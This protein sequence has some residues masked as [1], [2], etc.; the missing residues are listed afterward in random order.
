MALPDISDES[1]RERISYYI[2][3][4]SVPPIT[5]TTRSLLKSKLDGYEKQ[6]DAAKAKGPS[7]LI[8]P[9][10]TMSFKCAKTNRSGNKEKVSSL[11]GLK[12][13]KTLAIDTDEESELIT[14]ARYITESKIKD[15]DMHT[16][17][18]EIAHPQT[19]EKATSINGNNA[20]NE[21]AVS[22]QTFVFFDIEAT[23]LKSTTPKPRITEMSFVA[24]NAKDFVWTGTTLRKF[25]ENQSCS[26]MSIQRSIELIQPRVINKLTVCINPLKM[27][28]PNVSDLTGLDNYNL[29]S[30]KPFSKETA[31]LITQ[32]LTV[33]P[34]P[35]CLVAHNGIMYD[36]PLLNAEIS[37][38]D[39]G[40]SCLDTLNNILCVDSLLA[41]RKICRKEQNIEDKKR[42]VDSCSQ[43][44]EEVLERIELKDDA[45]CSRVH[46]HVET[47]EET[48]CPSVTSTP[49]KSTV[50]S[51]SNYANRYL[52]PVTPD[53]TRDKIIF[54]QGEDPD[55]TMRSP[56]SPVYGQK[57]KKRPKV[58]NDFETEIVLTTRSSR[59]AEHDLSDR[60]NNSVLDENDEAFITP[61]KPDRNS[62]TCQ[63]PPPPRHS[64]VGTKRFVTQSNLSE[65]VKA[66][67]KLDFSATD[68]SS[69]ET[70]ISFSLP[71]LHSHWFGT[72]PK[73][74]HGAEQDCM[75][76]MRVCAYKGS[77][78]MDYANL[79]ASTLFK[80]KKM[81]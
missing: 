23:G 4:T 72:E 70:P 26:S 29:E 21:K 27:I 24:I 77:D 60:I 28:M 56:T 41:L 75:A 64:K 25:S 9:S 65:V 38:L 19:N 66:K 14:H 53:K 17:E 51:T 32:F 33:L 42:D 71:K 45:Y 20:T 58:E 68:S 44:S 34:Q 11:E 73:L 5:N 39:L 10:I 8:T 30:T 40:N 76:L 55:S 47:L 81:W 67:K 12:E 31:E 35:V 3:P 2:H 79:N 50:S 61:D 7:S 74:S 54:F 18:V 57:L 15:Q 1:L 49:V 62:P 43:K 59:D 80:I 36:Y 6:Q 13:I 46:S 37:R 48:Q 52:L 16:V 69:D 78:F 63:P 22:I